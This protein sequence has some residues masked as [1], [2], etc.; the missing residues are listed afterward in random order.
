MY[1]I[2]TRYSKRW[3]DHMFRGNRILYTYNFIVHLQHTMYS[4]YY[5]MSYGKWF[6][7]CLSVIVIIYW[8]I[9]D[10]ESRRFWKY[11]IFVW[12]TRIFDRYRHHNNSGK[13]VS[14]K[15]WPLSIKNKKT[16]LIL[17]LQVAI[18]LMVYVARFG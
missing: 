11:S 10:R 5:I 18:G 13:K 9:A 7:A 2:R 4:I 8:Y 15:H 12:Y 17:H 16:S 14:I 6:N 1:A 3:F